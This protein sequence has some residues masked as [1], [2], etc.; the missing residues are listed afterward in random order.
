MVLQ[1]GDT[2]LHFHSQCIRAPW[3]CLLSNAP[4]T[5]FKTFFQYDECKMAFHLNLH[6]PDY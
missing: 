1:S 2:D 5:D 6:F 4:L 3:L